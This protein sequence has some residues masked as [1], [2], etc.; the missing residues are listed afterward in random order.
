MIYTSP[1]QLQRAVA[2]FQRWYNYERYH[3]ALGNLRP[4]EVYE[5]RAEQILRRRNEIK[6][7]TLQ[8]PVRRESSDKVDKLH[9]VFRLDLSMFISRRAK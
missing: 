6:R 3:Q 7:R 2:G 5:G 1:G 9:L 8:Q 4:A